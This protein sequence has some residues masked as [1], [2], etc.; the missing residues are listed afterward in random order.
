MAQIISAPDWSTVSKSAKASKYDWTTYFDGQCY[1]LA[2]GS[3]FTSKAPN[4]AN[5]AKTQAKKAG[6]VLRVLLDES[7]GTVTLQVVGDLPVA[8]A[9]EV[10]EAVAA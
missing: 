4:F 9:A 6:K 8:P 10:T 7:A 1:L 5:L 3:D 2:A